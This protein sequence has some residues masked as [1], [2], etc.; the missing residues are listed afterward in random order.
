MTIT[1][2]VLTILIC[3]VFYLI[4]NDK[5]NKI[6]KDY[7]KSDLISEM[8]EIITHFNE[9]ADRNISLLEEKIREIDLKIKKLEKLKKSLEEKELI[10]TNKKLKSNNKTQKVNLS[11]NFEFNEIESW[12]DKAYGMFL[13]GISIDEI[14]D[15]IGKNTGEIQFAISYL[16][17]KKKL[18]SKKI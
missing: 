4:L 7:I 11:K 16:E 1:V 6:K 12:Q 15:K 17:M 9:E 10:E 3:I 2:I 14:A 18:N 5:I 13:N 8:K